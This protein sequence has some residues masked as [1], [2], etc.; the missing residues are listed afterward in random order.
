[1]P[2]DDQ[3]AKLALVLIAR[4]SSE[5]CILCL[6]AETQS[7]NLCLK[8]VG[9]DGSTPNLGQRPGMQR[10]VMVRTKCPGVTYIA[11]GIIS[12]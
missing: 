1:M 5:Q 7:F 12:E 10:L 2:S 8:Y 4:N 11:L 9:S 3:K 6:W